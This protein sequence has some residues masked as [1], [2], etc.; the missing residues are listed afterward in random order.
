MPAID[1]QQRIA[2]ILDIE[3]QRL[4]E[5]EAWRVVY[6]AVVAL[7]DSNNRIGRYPGI[8]EKVRLTREL[9]SK[10]LTQYQIADIVDMGQSWVSRVVRG[11]SWKE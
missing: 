9:H 5:E 6:E 2:H 7:Q 3:P 11:L 10:G 8:R 1:Y 4:E